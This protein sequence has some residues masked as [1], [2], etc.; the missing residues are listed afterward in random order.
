MFYTLP[1]PGL[2][3]RISG[4]QLEERLANTV[5]DM[6]L[7]LSLP[8]LLHSN[9]AQQYCRWDRLGALSYCSIVKLMR[10]LHVTQPSWQEPRIKCSTAT[11][12]QAVLLQT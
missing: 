3:R 8:R 4:S 6:S 9:V 2:R 1:C 10:R 12:Q 7:C 11:C 5:D